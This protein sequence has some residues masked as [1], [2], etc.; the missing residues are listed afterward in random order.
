MVGGWYPVSGREG[1][2]K[3]NTS[4]CLVDDHK[5]F[6]YNEGMPPFDVESKSLIVILSE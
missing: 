4:E 3:E 2:N 1:E 5:F 6:Q